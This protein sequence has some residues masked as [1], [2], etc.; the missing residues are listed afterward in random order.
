MG[1]V[2]ID[3]PPESQVHK[4]VIRKSATE[5]DI[6]MDPA[7]RALLRRG[8]R[9][10]HA[11]TDRRFRAAAARAE[12]AMADR[13]GRGRPVAAAP[14]AAG[15]AQ[16]RMEG[17]RRAAQGQPRRTPRAC[18][19]S[20]PAFTKARSTGWPSTLARPPSPRICAT[21]ATGAVLASSG[22]M[23]PQIRF[24]EDLMSR[25][26]YA[27]MNPGGDVEMTARRARGDQRAG[28]SR[29]RPRR[30]VTRPRSMRWSSSAT[31][32]C[33]TCCWAST[34]S[35]WARRRLRW[36]PRAACRWTRAIWTWPA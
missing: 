13:R 22:V 15:P 9:A 14:V 31:R 30:D 26:S 36:P 16:G 23:N 4:Q 27:M 11:R 34:R 21:C 7:T 8:R 5:R 1:D 19:T 32:S 33:T 17:H 18:S 3:V 29:S 6:V 20:G 25:V 12:R 28:R 24:G 10:R 35:N 2:V